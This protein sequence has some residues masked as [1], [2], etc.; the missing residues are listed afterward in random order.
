MAA[1]GLFKIHDPAP[2]I[3]AV[4]GGVACSVGGR[5]NMSQSVIG[6]ALAGLSGGGDMGSPASQVIGIAYSIAL[7]VQGL[8]QLTCFI[9]D[10]GFL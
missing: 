6:I 1:V 2:V 5:N 8:K 3:Q 10:V 9:I 7:S 4:T